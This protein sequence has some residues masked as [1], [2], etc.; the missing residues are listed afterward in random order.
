MLD[1][2]KFS[3]SKSSLDKL[4]SDPES[5]TQYSNYDLVELGGAQAVELNML[6]AMRG[7]LLGEVTE[8]HRNYHAPISNTGSG[9]ML[10]EN[11]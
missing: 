10:L 8:L 3:S 4:V 2:L 6:I 7:A 11:K 5:L 9:L 1:A